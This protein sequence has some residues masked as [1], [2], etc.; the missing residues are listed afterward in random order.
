M[1]KLK[2]LQLCSSGEFGGKEYIV[3]SIASEID[4]DKFVVGNVVFEEG[5]LA[6]KMHEAGLD[7]R[8]L[9]SR[10]KFSFKTRN[11]L[12]GIIRDFKPDILHVHEYKDHFYGRLA[13]GRTGVPILVRTVHSDWEASLHLGKM[14]VALYRWMEGRAFGATTGF[15][16]VSEHL[17]GYLFN[18]GV[19]EKRIRT[20]PNGIDTELFINKTASDIFRD[21]GEIRLGVIGRLTEQKGLFYLFKAFA[22]LVNEEKLKLHLYVIGEGYYLDKLKQ[23]VDEFKIRENVTFTGFCK[24]MGSVFSELDLAVMPSLS[25]G[26][27]ITL[28][29][30]MAA[31]VP[32]IATAVGGIPSLIKDGSVGRLV[33]PRDAEAL[34]V[35][36]AELAASKELRNEISINAKRWIDERYSIQNTIEGYQSFY[37]ELYE[38]RKGGL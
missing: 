29:E 34:A 16:V 31:G 9:D 30:A 21:A 4:S 11:D 35:A 2:V 5:T 22:G 12:I 6:G 20:I 15:A 8:V 1:R 33:P 17:R 32:V 19:P 18:R 36:I 3:S 23:A 26:L 14:K 24:D 10:S 28:L 13:A 38:Q 25:E 37:S 7:C 27:P